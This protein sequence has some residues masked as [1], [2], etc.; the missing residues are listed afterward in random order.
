VTREVKSM[1][2]ALFAF[3]L[4]FL[5]SGLG[6]RP[7]LAATSIA[8]FAVTATVQAGCQVSAP[9]TAFGIYTTAGANATSAVSVACTHPTAYSVDLS[10]GLAP[11]DTATAQKMRGPVSALLDYR[12][13][14]DYARTVNWGRTAGTDTVTGTGNGSSP[15]HAVFGQTVGAQYVAPGAYAD[16]ITVTVTY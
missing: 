10:A 12:L 3:S 1:K 5:A 14:S 11:G 8:S 15:A 2:Y 13:L 4:G 16:T 6:S 7:V 9:A